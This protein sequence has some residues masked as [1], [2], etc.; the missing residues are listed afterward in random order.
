MTSHRSL[1]VDIRPGGNSYLQ[2]HSLTAASDLGHGPQ[3]MLSEGTNGLNS[4]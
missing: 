3:A 4:T 2:S 1:T